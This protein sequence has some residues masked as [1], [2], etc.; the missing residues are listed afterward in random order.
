MSRRLHTSIRSALVLLP[1]SVITFVFLLTFAPAVITRAA[2]YDSGSMD[3]VVGVDGNISIMLPKNDIS[4]MIDASRN[5]VAS[6]TIEIG[7]DSN[8][9]H[10]VVLGMTTAYSNMSSDDITGNGLNSVHSYTIPALDSTVHKSLFPTNH[11]GYSVDGGNYYSRMPAA[12]DGFMAQVVIEDPSSVDM[13]EIYIGNK[14]DISQPL[15]YYYTTINFTA[16]TNFAAK[17][18]DDIIYMQEMTPEV[19]ESMETNRQYR[20]RDSRDKKD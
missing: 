20:L 9:T 4:F 3:F 6:Q 10:G 8:L 16:I 7:V 2:R 11:W 18:I 19:V 1:V 17:T 5:E 13:Q 15:D 14:A 12:N